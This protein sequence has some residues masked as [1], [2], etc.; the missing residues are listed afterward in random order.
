MMSPFDT[1]ICTAQPDHLKPM[2]EHERTVTRRRKDA[3]RAAWQRVIG[4]LFRLIPRGGP[5]KA[6]LSRPS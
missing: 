2:S 3:R 6:T 5:A 4:K 1:R